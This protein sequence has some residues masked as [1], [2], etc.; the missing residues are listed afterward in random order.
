[1]DRRRDRA[2]RERAR[3]A[4]ERD[5]AHRALVERVLALAQRPVVAAEV[6]IGSVVA[7]EHEQRVLA[8]PAS[9]ERR[10][11]PADRAIEARHLLGASPARLRERLSIQASA[12]DR[13]LRRRVRHVERDVEE[14]RR[15]ERLRAD[16]ALGFARDQLGRV[17]G[18][19]RRLAV[20]MPV[21]AAHALVRV[22]VDQTAV[23]AVVVVEPAGERQ[24][25][26]LALPEVPLAE[27]HGV[28][29]RV[30]QHLGDRALARGSPPRDGVHSGDAST[31]SSRT[32]SFA[33]RSR[34]G[35]WIALPWC[36]TSAQPRSSVSITTTLGRAG[37]DREQPAKA[38]PAHTA[39][40]QGPFA[41]GVR[42]T[43]RAPGS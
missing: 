14:Q 32:T 42:P 21:E 10:D 25:A 27:H 41:I 3:P 28:V 39:T 18:L 13:R 22:G 1:M 24:V 9:I 8:R 2:R 20:A 36:P 26:A 34:L 30:A 12:I 33:K 35:V 16:H 23:G 17:A 4:R 15:V 11:D 7:R 19:D 5:H 40:I 43:T 29:A 31:C 37:A 6:R 38:A